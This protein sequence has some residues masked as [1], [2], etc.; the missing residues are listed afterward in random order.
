MATLLGRAL[1]LAKG[2]SRES[3][4][5]GERRPAPRPTNAVLVVGAGAVG[6]VIASALAAADCEV[7]FLLK[8]SRAKALAGDAITLSTLC[9]PLHA[10]L[11][12]SRSAARHSFRVFGSTAA[13]ATAR[14][15]DV[16]IL[17]VAAPALRDRAWLAQAVSL[18]PDGVLVFVAG[19]VAGSEYG[20]L[21][22]A[23][24]TQ[25][26]LC[27][28]GFTCIAWQ[29]PLLRPGEAAPAA[30][31]ATPRLETHYVAPGP[32]LLAGQAAPALAARLRVGGLGCSLVAS[33]D[34]ELLHADAVLLPLCCALEVAGWSFAALRRDAALRGLCAG[35]ARE[36]L[37]VAHKSVGASLLWWLA[38]FFVRGWLLWLLAL[39]APF[40]LPFDIEAYLHT[41]FGAKGA[42]N[43]QTR[44]FLEGFS[45][46][47]G[48]SRAMP[49][50]GALRTRNARWEAAA[51]GCKAD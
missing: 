23:G 6:A 38:P 42:V 47:G 44:L 35:A 24:A 46:S 26:Q 30:A 14:K 19:G 28:L 15:W 37:A 13:A 31:A 16:V 51:K 21:G 27:Q 29:P 32:L 33:V 12:R 8:P 34:A 45:A 39:L 7:A 18:A 49:R 11:Q 50:L 25:A 1:R 43:G 2:P 41:H 36:C 20:L 4:E 10:M 9:R 48:G 40:A 17:A 3:G 5:S 22:E